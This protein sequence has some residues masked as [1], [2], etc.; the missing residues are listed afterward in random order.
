MFEAML[1][2]GEGFVEGLDKPVKLSFL[3]GRIS[4]H[5]K[6]ISTANFS[7]CL[8]SGVDILRR[9]RQRV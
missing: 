7:V 8:W 1:E 9:P 2:V 3:S 6:A 4:T 5:D